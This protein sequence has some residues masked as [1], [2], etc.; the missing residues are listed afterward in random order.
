[1]SGRHSNLMLRGRARTAALVVLSTVV[2]AL[3]L[4]AVPCHAQVS[5]VNEFSA[6]PTWKAPTDAEVRKTV[7]AWLDE[8]KPTD[9]VRAEVLALWPEPSADE[10]AK[11][12]DAES[13]LERV[14]KSLALVDPAAKEIVELC[15]QPRAVAKL[16]DMPVLTDTKA[17]A[18]ERNH[19]RLLLGRW[20]TQQRFYD[21]GLAQLKDLQPNDVVDPAALLFYQGVCQHWMLHKEEGLKTIG[22]LLEQKKTIPRRYEQVAELMQADLSA[23]EDESLD[24]I[25]RRMNDV[26]RRLDF[27]H[28][29]KKVRGEEDGIIASL[30]KLIKQKEDAANAAGSGE[31]A[32]DESQ[33]G[34]RRQFR[35]SAGNS[36]AQSGR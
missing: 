28:A 23:L 35:R 6:D 10:A 25:S 8:C 17:P 20:L 3:M 26:T 14:G 16:P 11:T 1:M 34:A 15:A 5:L 19:L 27:G 36:F 30:D 24:H 12:S 22:K 2:P 31:G 21:D 4:I 9:A 29:G 7:V 33:P 18:F 13:L 32:G